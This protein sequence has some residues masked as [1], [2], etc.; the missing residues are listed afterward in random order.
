V[1]AK[2]GVGDVLP[3]VIGP[4][5]PAAQAEPHAEV[6]VAELGTRIEGI[7][8]S[9]RNLEAELQE[10]R[11]FT[12]DQLDSL[13]SRLDVLVL[14]QRDLTL[15]RDLIAPREQAAVGQVDSSRS[16]V[17]LMGA[18]IAELR[19]RNRENEALPEA[20]RT[21]ALKQLDELSDRLATLT[22]EK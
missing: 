21:A 3:Q 7:N 6:N 22:A 11:D 13:L 12:A 18:R 20:A 4:R 15:F 19:S 5:P 10:K 1:V 14:R 9:L 8:L 16:L 2:P 17:A